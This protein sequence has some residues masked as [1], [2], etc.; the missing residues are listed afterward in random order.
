MNRVIEFFISLIISAANFSTNL[1]AHRGDD[2][3]LA[4]YKEKKRAIVFG[5][6]SVIVVLLFGWVA[7]TI[8]GA[9]DGLKSVQ[10]PTASAREWVSVAFVT[11]CM[12]SMAFLIHAMW[13]LIRFQ[14]KHIAG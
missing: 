8:L 11:G 12:L 7:G 9:L 2:E 4:E 5:L 13:S 3:L 6:F 10:I 1:K 14:Q